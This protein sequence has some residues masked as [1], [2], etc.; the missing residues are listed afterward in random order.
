MT[1]QHVVTA[2]AYTVKCYEGDGLVK[3]ITD[4]R[5]QIEEITAKYLQ[6]MEEK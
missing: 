6:D 4:I 3:A 1:L 5:H 2:M